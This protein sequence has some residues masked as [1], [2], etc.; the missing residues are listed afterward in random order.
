MRGNI[1]NLKLSQK[2]LCEYAKRLQNPWELPIPDNHNAAYIKMES[3]AENMERLCE[4]SYWSTPISH[5][6]DAAFY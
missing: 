5:T 2:P 1:L 3:F 4:G 6:Q